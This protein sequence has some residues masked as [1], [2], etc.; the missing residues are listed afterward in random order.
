[1]KNKHLTKNETA[2]YFTD[3]GAE[4]ELISHLDL[5]IL[6]VGIATRKADLDVIH[7]FRSDPF[8]RLYY[9]VEETVDLIFAD[10]RH[11]LHPGHMYLIPALQPFRYS[12]SEGFTHYWIHFCSSQLEKLHFSQYP[13]ECLALDDVTNLMRSLLA[14]GETGSG[15]KALCHADII[16]RKLLIPFLELIPEH[17]YQKIKAIGAYQHVIEYINRNLTS[18][19]SIPKLAMLVGMNRNKFSADFHRVFGIPPKQYICNRRI[20]QAKIMLLNTDLSIKEIG[21]AIGYDNE[22]FFSRL[23]KKY[24]GMSPSVFRNKA[25]LAW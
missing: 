5:N 6:A 22:F 18:K 2:Y 1:M 17:D 25:N 13:L 14:F 11:T 12:K 21:Y 19:L 15:I 16:L 8:F 23:F 10:S 7:P 3:E 4:R 24:T 20:G 9:I